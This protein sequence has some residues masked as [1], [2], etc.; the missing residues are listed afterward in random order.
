M[1]LCVVEF[2]FVHQEKAIG[3]MIRSGS[4]RFSS[5]CTTD[6][7]S[8]FLVCMASYEDAMSQFPAYSCRLIELPS[9]V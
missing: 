7:R 3:D 9:W 2:R 6:G 1:V 8:C 4:L 5:N